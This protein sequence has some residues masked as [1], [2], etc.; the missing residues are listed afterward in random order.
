MGCPMSKSWTYLAVE[1]P[2]KSS[3]EHRQRVHINVLCLYVSD[4]CGNAVVA[5]CHAL[6]VAND[7]SYQKDGSGSQRN[8]LDVDLAQQISYDDDRKDKEQ[9]HD[10]GG[11][12]ENM[13]ACHFEQF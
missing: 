1:T 5:E 12:A 7:Q 10:N 2:D 6:E 9:D 13:R 4:P 3:A 11:H 8:A